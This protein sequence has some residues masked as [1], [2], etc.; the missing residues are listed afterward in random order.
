MYALLSILL[1]VIA[2]QQIFYPPKPV[3]QGRRVTLPKW[4]TDFVLVLQWVPRSTTTDSRA[5]QEPPQL[6]AKELE[7]IFR[8]LWL[9]DLSAE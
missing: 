6:S 4:H 5:W 9:K 1:T 8:C 7:F 3:F 2:M